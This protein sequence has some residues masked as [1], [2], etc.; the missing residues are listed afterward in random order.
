MQRKTAAAVE[1]ISLSR[2]FCTPIKTLHSGER[3]NQL[4]ASTKLHGSLSRYKTTRVAIIA[5]Y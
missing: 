4:R 5:G 2:D 1:R 3:A